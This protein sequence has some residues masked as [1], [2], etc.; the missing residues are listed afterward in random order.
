MRYMRTTFSQM[1]EEE[2]T[3]FIITTVITITNAHSVHINGISAMMLLTMH[4]TIHC[5]YSY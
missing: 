3:V 1:K 5:Y 2:I 4:H